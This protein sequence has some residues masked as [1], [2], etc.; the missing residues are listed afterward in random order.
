VRVRLL[1][2]DEIHQI[3]TVSLAGVRCGRIGGKDGEP[4]E[5]YAEEVRFTYIVNEH[6]VH[7]INRPD[8][9][10]KVV[11]SSDSYA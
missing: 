3:V 2:S 9:S 4:N 1:L 7:L 5:P 8:S 6:L 11:Y 10:R